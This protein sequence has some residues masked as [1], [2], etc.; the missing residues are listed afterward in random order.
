[1]P[2]AQHSPT[3]SAPDS[4]HPP[5]PPASGAHSLFFADDGLRPAWGLL[6]FAILYYALSTA[7][8]A[9]S[10]LS[11]AAPPPLGPQPTISP[12]DILWSDGLNA[13]AVL[14]TTFLMSRIERRPFAHY[15]LTGSRVLSRIA[16]G[17]GIGVASVSLL[18]WALRSAHVLTFDA[19][20]LAG[21]AIFTSAIL[22]LGAFLLVGLFE[23]L[24]FRG[25]L[26]ATL[27]RGLTALY[28][29]LWPESLSR[30]QRAAFWTSALLLSFGFGFVHTTNPG[31]SPL[32]V[33]A[34]GAIA[35]VFCLSLW[36]T[37]S[38]WWA[39]GFHVAWDWGESYLWGVYDSGILSRERLFHTHPHG[40]IP[41]S[42]G[43][44]G[45]EGS[46][47]VFPTI[48]LVAVVVLL[49]LHRHPPAP[50]VGS[51]YPEA[52]NSHATLDLQTHDID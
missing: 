52:T 36:R 19:R 50:P 23:E 38:L 26:Q 2:T 31:E 5:E 29:L 37:G 12:A 8:G 39:I 10:A 9:A 41:L 7:L 46:I 40:S 21:P 20:V 22:W 15:G 17:A 34:T 16:A 13:P 18:V 48:A 3:P 6:L 47:L 14:L 33:F 45:P 43:L 44:T 24:F 1:M 11:R 25:Y 49:T 28:G 35:F 27:T 4:P 51:P 42:G 30:A 32:G